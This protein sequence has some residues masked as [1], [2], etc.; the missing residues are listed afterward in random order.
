MRAGCGCCCWPGRRG[1]VGAAGRGAGAVR[2]VVAAASQVLMPLEAGLGEGLA[3]GEEVRRAVPFFAARLGVP[4]PEASL[5][6]VPRRVS[7]GC[8]TCMRRRWSRCCRPGSSP[9]GAVGVD[10][11]MVLETLLGHEKHYWQGRAR[12]AGLLAGAGGLSM[13]QL[14]QVAAAGCLLGTGDGGG[15]GGRVPGVAVTEAVARWLRELYPPGQDGQLGV[16]R[17]DRLAELHVSR[18]LGSSPELARGV[19]DRPGRPAGPPGAGACWP[20]PPPSTR[21]RAGCWNQ[22]SA[23]SPRWSP[24]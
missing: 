11:A 1:L 6:S 7:C 2:D 10:L 18:E 22:R 15:A 12:A 13:A 9:R 4:P 16:L 20:G 17:P 19:P 5:V 21:P 3:A 24:S 14:S 8:W 23:G